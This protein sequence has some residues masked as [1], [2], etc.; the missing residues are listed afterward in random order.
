MISRDFLKLPMW[1]VV[2]EFVLS[3]Q[4]CSKLKNPRHHP[5]GFLQPLP[6]PKQP[7]S[8][9]FIDFFTNLSPSKCFDTIFVIIDHLKKKAHFIS[10]KK[11]II[12][13]EKKQYDSL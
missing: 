6:I 1:K 5:Y 7:W 2:K 9:V 11:T 3:C 10:Y 4:T 8:F 12:R 13:E